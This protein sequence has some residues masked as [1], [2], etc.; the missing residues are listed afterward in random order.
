MTRPTIDRRVFVV[1]VP[2]SGTTLVQSLLAAHS[3]MTSFTESHFFD[4]HFTRL[5]PS[6]LSILSRNPAP[7]LHEFLLENCEAPPDAAG[8]RRGFGDVRRQ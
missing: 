7:R 1:G 4:R 2:R 6:S 3:T 5:P 8:T